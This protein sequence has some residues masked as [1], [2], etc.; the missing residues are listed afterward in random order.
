MNK[1]I[2]KWKGFPPP[3]ERLVAAMIGA[4]MLV[5]GTFWLGWTGNYPSIPW[6][7]PAISTVFVGW[8]ISLVFIA[9]IVSSPPAL[10]LCSFTD[11]DN[12]RFTSLIPTC[13]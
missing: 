10:L 11:D 2:P 1:I 9:F 5:V 13:E 4:V 6:Y 7:V 12:R 3:E 8:A